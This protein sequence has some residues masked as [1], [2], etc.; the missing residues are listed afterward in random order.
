[1]CHRGLS[2]SRNVHVRVLSRKQFNNCIVTFLARIITLGYLRYLTEDT[3]AALE[4]QEVVTTN[5]NMEQR[6]IFVCTAEHVSGE[7]LHHQ[8]IESICVG[9]GKIWENI[10]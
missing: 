10:T 9:S 1:M 5:L 3:P 7:R 6:C 2:A 8:P 4:S